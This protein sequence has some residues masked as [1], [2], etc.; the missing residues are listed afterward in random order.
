MSRI[1]PDPLRSAARSAIGAGLAHLE[2]AVDAN[3]I[4]PCEQHD[5]TGF[6]GT[7]SPPFLAASGVLALEVC[8]DPQVEEIV[9]RSRSFI[10]SHIESP[11]LWRWPP[12][13]FDLDSTAVCTLALGA[14]RH[15]WLFLGRNVGPILSCRDGNGRFLTWTSPLGPFGM[16][17]DADPVVNAN[18]VAWLGDRAETRAAQRWIEAVV[19]GKQEAGSSIWYDWPTDIYYC[20]SRAA[21]VAAPAFQGLLPTLPRRI[22]NAELDDTLRVAQALSSLL[23]LRGFEHAGFLRR[24]AERLIDMQYASGGWPACEF[25]RAPKGVCTYWSAALTTACCIEA[26]TRLTRP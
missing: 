14:H 20:V 8:N 26:L 15:A 10:L 3:G 18:I 7:P 5:R 6:S 13:G 9:A 2:T 12:F 21:S 16:P 19:T 1:I 25:T 11:G 23:R 17:N 22:L 4:W 24:C